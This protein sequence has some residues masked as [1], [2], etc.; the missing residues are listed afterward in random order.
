[1]K[2]FYTLFFILL[3]FNVNGQPV[4]NSSEM[5]PFGTI[6]QEHYVADLDVIDTTIQGPNQ[7][8][9]FT[10]LTGTGNDI[11]YT[12]MDPASTPYAS[13]FPTS[14]YAYFETPLNA[15][16]YFT[17]TSTMF[18]RI[19]SYDSNLNT[20]S[21][22]Q[23]EY[24]F[25]MQ[26]GTTNLDTWASTASSFGGNYNITCI[27]TG[28][29]KLPMGDFSALMVRVDAYEGFVDWIEY[30]WYD[31]DNGVPLIARAYGDGIF[32]DDVGIYMG[33]I[34]SGIEESTFLKNLKYNNPVN[35]VLQISYVSKQ[36]NEIHYTIINS[37]G[38]W[39]TKGAIN[40]GLYY[41]E[42]DFSAFEKG[43][44]FLEFSEGNPSKAY[45]IKIVKI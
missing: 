32:I 41:S 23:I 1:M 8:W 21:D 13:F 11:F 3:Y 33:S 7:T 20:Y 2:K 25:P 31:A 36:Q 15:Y 34:T 18:E 38:K 14:N 45:R 27:G 19:G 16:S 44:Y 12:T 30:F 17:L 29:L 40:D 24:V 4:L 28:T 43:I 35:D 26:F 42:I 6:F 22:S 37:L 5:M 10:A 39:V 9:D